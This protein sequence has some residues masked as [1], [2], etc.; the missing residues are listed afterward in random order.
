MHLQFTIEWLYLQT[1][2][3]STSND[4]LIIAKIKY[5]HATLHLNFGD[6][7]CYRASFIEPH[8]I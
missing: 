7:S 1:S 4:R 3:L 8:F 5:P 6:V 2:L